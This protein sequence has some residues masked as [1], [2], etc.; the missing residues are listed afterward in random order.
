[1]QTPAQDT[2]TIRNSNFRNNNC[3]NGFT[4]VTAIIQTWESPTIE[5]GGEKPIAA[6]EDADEGGKYVSHVAHSE[7][8]WVGLC[9]V[10]PLT[11]K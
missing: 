7:L 4:W 1:M 8:F 11:T 9:L 5:A 6:E 2:A 3:N 10:L